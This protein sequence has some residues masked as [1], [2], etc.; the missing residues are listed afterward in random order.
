MG[1]TRYER[2]ESRRR[3][4]TDEDAPR[5]RRRDDDDDDEPRGRYRDGDDDRPRKK[6]KKKKKGGSGLIIGLS[7]GVLVLVVGV[8]ALVLV[9]V[10]RGNKEIGQ[11]SADKEEVVDPAVAKLV[12]KWKHESSTY[13]WEFKANGTLVIETKSGKQSN[14]TYKVTGE[15]LEVTQSASKRKP[16]Q[17]RI[18][19]QRDELYLHPTVEPQ[20]HEIGSGGSINVA[21]G[22]GILAFRLV[23]K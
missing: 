19:R 21:V 22:A 2:D 18:D 5:R 11:K 9:L 12:G 6:K 20:V 4:R 8:G 23:K 15:L 13:F 17:Y 1:Q 16:I 3:S 14:E 10:L 7:V